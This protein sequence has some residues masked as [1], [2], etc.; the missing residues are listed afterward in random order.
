M[1]VVGVTGAVLALQWCGALQLM[2][3]T[4][5]DRWFR[6]RP[7]EEGE[8]RAVIVTIDEPDMSRM[9]R[10]PMSDATLA[11]L[12]EKL[13][14]QQPRAIGLDLYRN[15]PVEPGH[16]ELLKVLASTPNLIGIQK[17]LSDARGP[18][19]DPPPILQ[20]R[21]QVAA[22]DLVVDAD[23]KVRRH[24][25][26][27]R[28]GHG[29]TNMT[30]GTKLAL[31]YLESQDMRLEASGKDRTSIKLGKAKFVP[32]E[33]NEGGYVRADVG[34]YQILAN[35]QRLRG[36]FPKIS[37]TDVLEDRIP[38]NL[39][40]GRIVLIG[41]VAESLRDKFYTPYTTS[42]GTV[43][44]G[45]ELH[46]NLA[47]QILSAALDGRQLLRG[48]PQPLECLWVF[49]WSSVGAAVGWKVRSL[50]WAVVVIPVACGSLVGSTY[51]FFLAGWWVV[52]A[53]PFLALVSAGVVSRGYLLWKQLQHS[54]DRLEDYA[55]TLE[56]KVRQRTR[57]L[58]EKEVFLRSIY[59]GVAESIFVV[60]VLEN[61][62]FQYVG[63]NPALEI[64]AGVRSI[65]LQGKTPAQLFPPD[66]A[67]A[68][69]QR[70][71]DCVEAGETITYEEYL[72]F[73]GQQSWWFTSLTPLRDE[74]ER[75]YRLIGC[76]I[77]ISD[78]KQ[79]EAALKR[80]LLSAEAANE[81]KSTFLA[82]MS[83]ELRTP[84]N[85]ILGYAQILQRGSNCTSKQKEGFDIIY[86]CG[87]HL[88]TLINDILDLSKIEAGKL[89]LYP[90]DFHFP[91]FLK[92]LSDIFSLKAAQKSIHFTCLPLN[93]LPTIVHA[94]HK[95]LRQVLMN[96]LSNAVKF[97]DT[98]SVTFKVGVIGND[99]M[100]NQDKGKLSIDA[101][102]ELSRSPSAERQLP[103]TKIR[104]QVEDTGVGMTP[105]QLEKIFLPFEQVGDS[106]RRAEGT[107]LGLAITQKFVK[108]MGSQIFVESCFGVGSIF[109]FDLDVPVVSMPIESITVNTDNIIG[110]SGSKQRILVVDDRWENRAVLINM[111]E[112]IG[113]ELNE[114]ANGQ[115]GLEK[116]VE[117]QPDLILADLLMPVMDGFEMTRRLR[118]LPN[119]QKTT[120]IAI[121]ANAFLVNRQKSLK[122]G[123]N[124]FLSKPVQTE[125]FIDK[126]KRYLNLSWVY[127][128]KNQTQFQEFG[129]ES[130]GYSQT[131][132]TE[133][134][135]PPRD[136]LLALYEATSLYDVISVEQEAIRLKE[137]NPDYT[138]FVTRI[139]EH[140]ENFDYEEITKFLDHYLYEKLEC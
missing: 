72:T 107:G 108:L 116:A 7:P 41:T 106:S 79:A 18:A 64:L 56:L 15:L 45:V 24:L 86:Q 14:Q 136:A 97:T 103:I 73:Q 28:D 31:A 137:L 90:E 121:S 98:G 126:I 60:D 62:D 17:A 12:L 140:A 57:E 27:L 101:P 43:W 30:L 132:L 48:L 6:L 139:L 1:I 38:A 109:G 119:F 11:K 36:G 133:M 95:R 117:F 122:A 53:S 110:Y 130:N 88:L 99:I 50:G 77:N 127:D 25:L 87:T 78:R 67:A 124:D 85:G 16:Q 29:K 105:E 44:S 65:E 13:K 66:E 74:Q 138:F 23:G 102:K 21:D 26:S 51:L 81:A 54:H 68:V 32:L 20:E 114:A 63:L 112:P 40:R 89:E 58:Q 10:W 34:G 46:A 3:S 128:D 84:L 82:N 42:A 8:S 69:Q 47:S 111:L 123:C 113:F 55:K 19:V 2:E 91:S 83:H 80:A 9:G 61:G 49:L 115:E 37:I 33:E 92:G 39:M 125:E 131:A 71:R 75:I 35:F 76:A 135:I 96:L 134:M 93:Q 22:C 120:I 5:L 104:F 4:V 129:Y 70:Y 118:Q 94:D 59:D 100:G 52:V